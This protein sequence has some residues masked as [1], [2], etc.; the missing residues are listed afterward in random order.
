M[1]RIAAILILVSAYFSPARALTVD[2]WQEVERDVL[3]LVNADRAALGLG[4]LTGDSRLHDAA[5]GHSLDMQVN[6]FTG[7][8]GSDGSNAGQRA[9]A[10][11]YDWNTW[12][13]N[14]AAG[15]PTA[16]SVFDAWL[17]SPGHRDNM[18]NGLFTD[19][20][21][22]FVPGTDENEFATYWTMV[23]AAGDSETGDPIVVLPPFSE[24]N[25][26]GGPSLL[27]PETVQV[28][29]V[30]LPP[31][32]WLFAAALAAGLLVQRRRGTGA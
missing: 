24:L 7:H 32:F 3:D 2:L 10:A 12:G 17:G 5:V 21:I 4:T 26:P 29:A 20:G 13:E 27:D 9:Q 16:Q 30:P 23:L 18:R 19:I 31:S 22:G 14:L 1:L 8:T 25:D 28:A 15:Q 11:G 6:N